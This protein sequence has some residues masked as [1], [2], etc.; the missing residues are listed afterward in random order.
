LNYSANSFENLS[1]I[2]ALPFTTAEDIRRDSRQFVTLPPHEIAR[3]V[4]LHSSGTTGGSKRFFFTKED[5]DLTLDFF[6]S[7][8]SILVK[9]RQKV[10]ILL[11]GE[12]PDSVGD[13]LARGLARIGVESFVHGPVLDVRSAVEEIIT[14]RIDCLVGIPTQ[15]LSLARSSAGKAI[16]RGMIK[17][18]LLSTDYIPIAITSEL[19]RVWDCLV[20]K[21]YGTTEMGLGGAVECPVRD[22]YHLR[23]ADLLFEIVDPDTGQPLNNGE[24]G[25]IVI[26][27]LTRQGMP[28]IRYRT[29]D[30]S[31]IIPEPCSCGSAT[32]RI[33]AVEGRLDGRIALSNGSIL[34]LPDMDEALFPVEGLLNYS[35][36]LTA[37]NGSDNLEIDIC[38]EREGVCSPQKILKALK[39]ITV[40]SNGLADGSLRILP[41]LLSKAGWFTTGVAKRMIRDCRKQQTS[42]SPTVNLF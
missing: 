40:I 36:I 13:L 17:S 37:G 26:T 30:L 15:V 20:F 6:S 31:H 39:N 32:R 28:L 22:G 41:I 29:G 42:E 9:P 21:H 7:G 16:P 19:A 14:R 25:E 33:G 3:I 5:L 12:K 35:A 24:V 23:E 18:V 1:Q 8:M 2:N 10:L 38:V 27:T 4:T 11:P 34:T